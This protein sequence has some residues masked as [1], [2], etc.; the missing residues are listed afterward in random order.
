MFNLGWGLAFGGIAQFFLSSETTWWAL[1]GIAVFMFGIMIS[2]SAPRSWNKLQT[3]LLNTQTKW[4]NCAVFMPFLTFPLRWSNSTTYSFFQT[5]PKRQSE[6]KI[7]PLGIYRIITYFSIL[8]LWRTVADTE[9]TLRWH[10]LLWPPQQWTKEYLMDKPNGWIKTYTAFPCGH[11]SGRRK[12]W[13]INKAWAINRVIYIFMFL[14]LHSECSLTNELILSSWVHD[15]V[16]SVVFYSFRKWSESQNF[17][18]DVGIDVSRQISW[19]TLLLD[20]FGCI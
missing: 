6:M 11:E 15:N 17:P 19:Q 5:V 10:C 20:F 1:L 3:G 4:W 12:K 9:L 2:T 7:N 13:H 14:L 18:F 16:K 8:P